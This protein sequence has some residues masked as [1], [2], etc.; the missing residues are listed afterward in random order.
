MNGS[1]K[2]VKWA[3]G[4]KAAKEDRF[5][6]LAA[7]AKLPAAIKAIEYIHNNQSASFWIDYRLETVDQMLRLL[8]TGD[9]HICGTTH[10]VTAQ[11]DHKTGIITEQWPV[12]RNGKIVK[13][14][15][16]L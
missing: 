8:L 15:K 11:I 5:A 14:A 1:E 6:T 3:E 9:L 7:V 12:E 16:T 2:Q 4:I 10:D 13:E